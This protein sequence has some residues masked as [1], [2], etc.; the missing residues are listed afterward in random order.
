MKPLLDAFMRWTRLGNWPMRARGG[1]AAGARWTLY[2]FSSYWRGTSDKE[3][4][5]WIDRFCKPGSSSLDLGAHFGLYSVG[6]AMRVGPTGQVV[7]LEP[8][9]TARKRCELHLRMNRLGWVRVFGEAASD[10]TGTIR[11]VGNGGEGS[12]T[13]FVSKDVGSGLLLPCVR[14][15]DLFARE[16]L[17][18]PDFIKI[19]VENHGAEA[20]AGAGGILS[21]RP[22]IMM[23]FHSEQELA[24]TKGI[25]MPLGYGVTSLAG[26][27][28]EWGDALYK[29]AILTARP[30]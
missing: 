30:S 22:N 13:S 3:S 27:S 5:V 6:M 2:P 12:T 29:T 20:L 16:R 17:R 15:D 18:P 7:A 23:S 19:D 24:G 28:V 21:G 14:L 1:L 25:L 26:E 10:R 9:R 8:E 4:T 11:F